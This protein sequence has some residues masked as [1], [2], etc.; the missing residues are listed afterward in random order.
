V[1]VPAAAREWALRVGGRNGCTLLIASAF[2]SLRGSEG[3]S[4]S[5]HTWKG[6]QHRTAIHVRKDDVAVSNTGFLTYLLQR[7]IRVSSNATRAAQ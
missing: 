2:R 6:G 4:Q 3:D 1:K 5:L 7:V